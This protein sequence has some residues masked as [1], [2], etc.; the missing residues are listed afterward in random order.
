MIDL[1]PSMSLAEAVAGGL[2]APRAGV[3]VWSTP[4]VAARLRKAFPWPV[5]ESDPEIS[6]T[7]DWLVAAGGGT[8]IDQAK[9]LRSRHAQVKLAA[10]PTLWGSGAEASPIAVTNET[11]NKV[12]R[13]DPALRPDLIIDF[14]DSANTLPDDLIRDACGDTWAHAIEGFLSPLGT[15]ATRTDLAAVI[16]RYIGLPLLYD[17]DWFVFSRLACAGQARTSVGLVHG[18]AHAL[19]PIVG[20]GHARLCRQF[21][22]PVLTFDA[23]HSPKWSLLARHGVDPDAVLRVARCLFDPAGYHAILPAV[24]ENWSR[25]IRDGCSRTNAA[26]V[27]P[28]SLK[29]FREFTTS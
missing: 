25:I 17:P 10:L 28:D 6:P 15:D 12:I 27:R 4:S 5:V 13:F 14:P 29:F 23:V 21:L 24:I 7:T 16:A 8:L 3:I 22:L 18:L 9:V 1:P 26:L 19:E 20:V 2:A 11:G